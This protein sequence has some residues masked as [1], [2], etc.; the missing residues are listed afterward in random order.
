MLEEIRDTVDSLDFDLPDFSVMM[1]GESLSYIQRAVSALDA[2][3]TEGEN[4]RDL[5]QF[6]WSRA[7]RGR[8]VPHWIPRGRWQRDV[9]APLDRARRLTRGRRPNFA[10]AV[11]LVNRADVN[12]RR[13]G[14]RSTEEGDVL[15]GHQGRIGNAPQD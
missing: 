11:R 2:L 13:M 7:R 3:D 14:G 6:A 4:I 9:V 5:V 10:Q 8:S 12:L 1:I 15:R